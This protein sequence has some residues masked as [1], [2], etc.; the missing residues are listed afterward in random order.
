MFP[1]G[2]AR[3]KFLFLIFIGVLF[4]SEALAQ[5]DIILST[6]LNQEHIGDLFLQLTPEGDILIKEEDLSKTRLK[7]NIGKEI[8]VEGESYISLKSIPGAAFAIKEEAASLE[9]Y[10]PPEDF[11]EQRLDI[12]YPRPYE[13]MYTNNASAFFNYSLLYASDNSTLNLAGELGARRW[14]W[15]GLTTFNYKKDGDRDNLTRL[16]TSFIKD[17][18][19]NMRT[20]TLGDFTATS[21]PL[22]SV[23][24][25]GGAS[26]S[27]NF[28]L[29]PYY[30]KY[31][32]VNFDGAL[33]YASEVDI[34][35]N[36]QLVRRIKVSPGLFF[37]ENIPVDVG[38]GNARIVIKDIFGRER[39][40]VR[41][42]FYSDKLLK[43]GLSEY[44]YNMGFVRDRVGEESFDYDQPVIMALHN[45]GV[46]DGLKL[47]YS[48]EASDELFNAGS[49]ISFLAGNL[50]VID[51]SLAASTSGGETGFAGFL[52]YTFR[53]RVINGIFSLRAESQK[54]ST[55][56]MKPE[57]DNPLLQFDG[58]IGMTRREL[59]SIALEYSHAETHAS[60]GMTRYALSYNR[61]INSWITFFA[62]G[63]RTKT[64]GVTSDELFAGIHVYLG[65][66]VSWHS[67]YTKRDGRSGFDASI[68]K[69][70]PF[71]TGFGYKAEMETGNVENRLADLTYQNNYGVYQAGYRSLNEKESLELSVSGGI[72]Y[73]DDSFFLSRPITDSFAKVEASGIEDVRV[74]YYGNEAGRTDSKGE[75]IIPQFRSY[76]DNRV[77]IEKKDIPIEYTIEKLEEFVNPPARSGSVVKF[78]LLKTQGISGF[79]F[80]GEVGQR[81]PAEFAAL[82]VRADGKLFRGIT[83]KGGEFYLEN[84]P[85]GSFPAKI[86]L[87]GKE[88]LFNM[89]VPASTDFF[90]ELGDIICEEE[91]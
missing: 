34:Y 76:Q 51:A 14:D 78:N 36:G 9:I 82:E 70:M 83:G 49:S 40:L 75:I 68:E 22:G 17:D 35:V 87:D 80:I 86:A 53:S 46:S 41:S 37:L 18:R 47:G 61:P 57:D 67:S 65:K 39:E 20:L 58:S 1:P 27:K 84:L 74:Y 25:L 69:S 54:Y 90:L 81:K 19:A 50:G 24:I 7:E 77:E 11:K 73:I 5:E 89:T 48:L 8:Q 16:F 29:N 28:S 33:E 42:F 55:V 32:P 60:S 30:L 3:L 13:S 88:C 79:I 21:G 91:K 59:G 72:G 2:C 26:Y 52:G 44:S 15:L 4:S 12:K 71:G 85:A 6:F 64:D 56:S 23:D 43:R 10:V 38:L 62:T 63:T 31:P 45:Y 66:N